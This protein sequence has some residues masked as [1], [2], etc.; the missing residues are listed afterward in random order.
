MHQQKEQLA[1]RLAQRRKRGPGGGERNKSVNHGSNLNN[2]LSFNLGVLNTRPSDIANGN[3]EQ[4]VVQRSSI[5]GPDQVVA[6]AETLTATISPLKRAATNTALN[7]SAFV[8]PLKTRLVKLTTYDDS[9]SENKS[10]TTT[11]GGLASKIGQAMS[12]IL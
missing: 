7:N 8:S 9:R 2:S 5:T 12:R 10:T 11:G 3:E 1:L 4:P 6:A